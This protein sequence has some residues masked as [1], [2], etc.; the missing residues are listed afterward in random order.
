MNIFKDFNLSIKRINVEHEQSIVRIVV[1]LLIFIG[2][3]I[4]GATYDSF[5]DIPNALSQIYFEMPI[6]IAISIVLSMHVQ[7]YPGVNPARRIF[8]IILDS[9]QCAIGMIIG[10][11]YA[12]MVFFVL[13]WVIVGNGIRFGYQYLIISSA[14][15]VVACFVGMHYSAYW[16]ENAIFL[17]GV[18]LTNVV[19][20]AYIYGLLRRIEKTTRQLELYAGQMK[21][22][23]FHDALTG[24][25]NRGLL[26]ENIDKALQRARRG[27]E[28]LA[29]V[30]F[31]LDGFKKVNDTLGHEVGDIL[32]KQVAD[33]ARNRVRS[34]DTVARLGGDEFVVLLEGLANEQGAVLVANDILS[35][36]QGITQVN[37]HPVKVGGSFGI[38]MFD[39]KVATSASI[40]TKDLLRWADEAMYLAK[41]A[42]KGRVVFY[43]QEAANEPVEGVGCMISTQTKRT[44]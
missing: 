29:V 39:P 34:N 16:S 20:P 42:G 14:M 15:S 11:A 13:S 25:A 23:A 7:M 43:R 32:L 22:A 27:N 33:I 5:D 37:G 30:F 8:G 17:Y 6:F 31:D 24:L 21:D 4:Y 1:S 18:M 38:A 2:F 40:A 10:G 19:V 35:L 44:A 3:L 28:Q 41:R 9:A 12:A 26:Q 36:I